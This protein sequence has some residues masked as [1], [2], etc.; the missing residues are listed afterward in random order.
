[1]RVAARAVET[2]KNRSFLGS[3]RPAGLCGPVAH[4][5]L[6]QPGRSA[7]PAGLGSPARRA[8]KA[9]RGHRRRRRSTWL[10]T[11]R[12]AQRGRRILEPTGRRAA[13]P[14]GHPSSDHDP[15]D[16]VD[17]HR[18]RRLTRRLGTGGTGAAFLARDLR[19]ERDVAV[20]TLTGVSV[21]RLWD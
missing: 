6:S 19:L 15:F 9:R 1:M 3:R 18:V 14:S 7:F 13:P 4:P 5:V 17:G 2:P 11:G 21:P 20:K 16:L 8:R 10:V 12:G